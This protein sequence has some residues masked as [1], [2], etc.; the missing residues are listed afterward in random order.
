MDII[1]N[2]AVNYTVF[3]FG[4]RKDWLFARKEHIGASDASAVLGL[5]PWRTNVQLWEEKMSDEEP[6][7]IVNPNIERGIKSEPHIRELY[8]IES[9]DSV[10]DGTGIM[11]VSNKH[12]FM[13]CTLD[14]ACI[15]KDGKPYI[16]EIK[17]VN[18]TRKWSRGNSIPDYY[19]IQLLH[20]MVVTG[21]DKAV[22][23]ARIIMPVGDEVVT[24]KYIVNRDDVGALMD[25]LI[26]KESEFAKSIENGIRPN[27][28]VPLPSI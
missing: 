19:F 21:W 6:V 23:L 15:D 18:W 7:E 24:R 28:I 9:G 1:R 20:Q 4:N 26:E 27:L 5:C 13:S 12:R 11:L 17:S 16:L 10:Q 14:G 8:A 3:E 25:G 22:L 2:N